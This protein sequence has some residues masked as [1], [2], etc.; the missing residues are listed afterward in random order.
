MPGV[1]S[2]NVGGEP[3]CVE[4]ADPAAQRDEGRARAAYKSKVRGALDPSTIVVADGGAGTHI[5][6]FR[7]ELWCA[8]RE[9]GLRCATVRHKGSQS[10]LPYSCTW[11]VRLTLRAHGTAPAHHLRTARRGAYFHAFDNRLIPPSMEEL[12]SRFEEPKPDAR[13]H[14]PLFVTTASA[15][16]G[17]VEVSPTPVEALWDALTTGAV[18]PPKGVTQPRQHTANNS[19]E[20]LDTVT[21]AV[22]VALQ[23]QRESALAGE[24]LVLRLAPPL[25]PPPVEVALSAGRAFPAPG[26]LQTLRRQF[27]RLYASKAESAADLARVC[28][29]SAQEGGVEH[30]V[31]R[32]FAA[33]LSETLG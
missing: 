12:I 5:K 28:G 19:L 24:R 33:W 15:M 20:L 22:V 13:W 32:M 27:V 30:R 3:P 21:Q 26:R 8:T 2:T 14:R 7:Y 16:D 6:G 11:T 17:G 23:Q 4:R 1:P 31:A 25:S 10:S 18:Q 9:L 29:G